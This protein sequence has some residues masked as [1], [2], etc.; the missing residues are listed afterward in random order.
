M[1][2]LKYAWLQDA[3]AELI[4]RMM[5]EGLYTACQDLNAALEK[6]RQT[7]AGH[8]LRA[9]RLQITTVRLALEECQSILAELG[10]LPAAADVARAL[11]RLPDTPDGGSAAAPQGH[12]NGG[13][14]H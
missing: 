6:I 3:L 5:A 2:H 7:D 13:S 1:P 4:R 10:E 11:Q 9:D 12:R 8:S 14:Y